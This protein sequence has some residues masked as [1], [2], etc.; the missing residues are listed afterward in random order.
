MRSCASG[1]DTDLSLALLSVKAAVALSRAGRRAEF[2][3]L[4]RELSD[5]YSDER[6]TIGGQTATPVATL[7]RLLGDAS[8]TTENRTSSSATAE[9]AGHHV[10][11]SLDLT[12]VVEPTWQLRFA[13]SIEAGMTPTELTQWESNSLSSVVPAVAIDGTS[14]LRE[15]PCLHFRPG[16]QERKVALRTASFHNLELIAMQQ[17]VR[18]VDTS[19]FDVI[20]AG[21][22]VWTLVRDLKDQNFFA[23]F[24]LNCRRAD[25]GELI[26]RTADLPEYSTYDLVSRPLLADGKLFITAKTNANPQQ[27]QG[28]PQQ[29]VMAIQPHDGKLLWKTEIG[30][31]RQ[32]QQYFNYYYGASRLPQPRL[33][34]RAG[35][36]YIDTHVGIFARLDADTGALDWGYG[37]K[38]DPL[39]GQNRFFFF[40]EYQ[41]PEKATT[42]SQPLQTGE[43]FL[44]KGMQSGRL[45]AVDPNRMK[46]LWERP[47]TK[48]ARCWEQAT[49]HFSRRLRDQLNGFAHAATSVGDA[50]SEW[51]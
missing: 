29:L 3:Q 30:M 45:Y 13:A 41:E 28:Q 46:V 27:Q 33:I 20:A 35:A 48:S 4:R 44:I 8:K 19:R 12:G 49:A 39:Q 14:N 32:G 16:R 51:Q 42:S 5:R 15:L 18:M 21:E 23:P 25:N 22:H 24:Q 37:Y 26:W 43:A 6:I 38:T 34:Y 17:N 36:V 31:F 10:E 1:P 47:I 40:G 2:E 9:R 50:D 7:E 11:P